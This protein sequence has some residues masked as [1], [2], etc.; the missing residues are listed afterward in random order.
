M[1]KAVIM[2]GGKGERFWPLTRETF[3]KY[4]MRLN[5][6]Q[7]LLAMTY[8]RLLRLYSPGAVFVVTTREHA[9]LICAEL[10]K[11]P[12]ANLLIEPDRRNTAAA[13]YFSCKVLQKKY[14]DDEVISFFPADHLIR[15]EKK[16][17]QTIRTAC[18]LA[19]EK[20]DLIA[21]GIS[22]T[23]PA[24]GYGYI[25]LGRRLSSNDQAFQ[26]SQFKEKPT[27]AVA[28]R[29]LSRGD[30]LWNGGIFTWRV[31]TFLNTMKKVAPAYSKMLSL[32]NPAKSYRKLPKLSIDYALLEKTKNIVVVKS[33]M[34]WCDIGNWD[35]FRDKSHADADHNVLSGPCIAQD[36]KGCLVLNH[37]DK[38][39]AVL[40][41]RNLVV[42]QTS[43]GT[44]ISNRGVSEEA[45]KLAIRLN[46]KHS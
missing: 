36:L 1:A 5:G 21:V 17:A 10:P 26:V 8:K 28:K 41:L 6:G 38:P 11:L 30:F 12:K 37:S 20:D 7:S 45:A 19:K 29:Y 44:L 25:H 27:L 34:D 32:R 40:G 9:G 42:V 33:D 15:N 23:F 18:R 43:Q 31:G 22:P 2:A 13:I 35:M 39:L 16:F 24:I 14:G 46:Q 4:R 3:P